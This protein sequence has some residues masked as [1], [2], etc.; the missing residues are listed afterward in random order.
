MYDD[1]WHEVGKKGRKIKTERGES[2]QGRG[3]A[4]LGPGTSHKG[5]TEDTDKEGQ[6]GSH[7][8]GDKDQEGDKEANEEEAPQTEG[9]NSFN[10]QTQFQMLTHLDHQQEQAGQVLQVLPLHPQI[11]NLDGPLRHP[12]PLE[13]QGVMEMVRLPPH[14]QIHNLDRPLQEPLGKTTIPAA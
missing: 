13:H 12:Q 8:D 5:Q 11:H 14:R 7:K 6:G 1:Q 9:Q 2:S 10:N 3:G 4:N